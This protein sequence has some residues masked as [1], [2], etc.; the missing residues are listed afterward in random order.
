MRATIADSSQRSEVRG[1]RS[2]A[3]GQRSEVRGQRSEVRGQ[4]SEIRRFKG[5]YLEVGQVELAFAPAERDVYSY[6]HTPKES[7]LQ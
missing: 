5:G 2:E 7:S 6:E 4:T 1:Q 3:R